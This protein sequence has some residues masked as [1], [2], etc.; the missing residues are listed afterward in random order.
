MKNISNFDPGK[1]NNTEMVGYRFGKLVITSFNQEMSKKL[2]ASVWNCKCDCGNE[3]YVER[4][5]LIKGT[6]ID[7]L[8]C[9]EAMCRPGMKF[10]KLTVLEYD[11]DS[12]MSRQLPVFKCVCDCG[13]ECSVPRKDLLNGSRTQCPFCNKM[14]SDDVSGMKFGML[15]AIKMSPDRTEKMRRTMWECKCDC[16]RTTYVPLTSLKSGAVTSCGCKRKLTIQLNYKKDMI[17]KKFGKLTVISEN[18]KASKKKYDYNGN[19]ESTVP[20]YDC[21]CDCGNKVTVAG[22][23]LR[24]GGTTSCGYCYNHEDLSGKRFGNLTVLNYAGSKE[25]HGT[26]Y[27]MWLCRCDC[28][29][30]IEV[31]TKALKTG[32]TTSCGCQSTNNLKSR[33]NVGIFYSEIKS[34]YNAILSRCY[35]PLDKNYKNYGGRG[36]VVCDRWL[37]EEGLTNFYND[38]LDG[39]YPGL[40]LDRKDVNGPYSPENCRWLDRKGQNYNKRNNIYVDYYGKKICLAELAEKFSPVYGLTGSDVS[41]RINSGYTPIEAI[42]RPKDIRV[43]KDNYFKDHRIITEPFKFKEELDTMNLYAEDMVYEKL[44]GDKLNNFLNSRPIAGEFL[45]DYKDIKFEDNEE[46]KK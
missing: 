42:Y 3:C 7:C 11:K 28:G 15:T 32:N 10:G 43:K 39:F 5:K 34:K 29:N 37:G 21:I 38:L 33:G 40:T 1:F 8:H 17:G 27:G 44:S 4:P 30:E 12:S 46:D 16:G 36:I 45:K 31:T 14:D 25:I 23:S 9:A 35:D 19:I 13:N 24:S 2:R 22:Y 26:K 20:Y 18:V 41:H 6:R